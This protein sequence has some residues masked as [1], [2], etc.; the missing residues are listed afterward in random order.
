MR[1]KAALTGYSLFSGLKSQGW[2]LHSPPR[3][4]QGTLRIL[5]KL[6]G[7][8]Q[9]LRAYVSKEGE[10]GVYR[11]PMCGLQTAAEACP[12]PRGGRKFLAG[13]AGAQAGP[14]SIPHTFLLQRLADSLTAN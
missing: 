13:F 12:K 9:G 5:S 11:R 6:P 8:W 1:G 7:N 2:I 14:R 10:A 4:G 3:W